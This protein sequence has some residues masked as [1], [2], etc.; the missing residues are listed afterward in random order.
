MDILA[1]QTCEGQYSWAEMQA[2]CYVTQ[3]VCESGVSQHHKRVKLNN[4]FGL[5]WT[6]YNPTDSQVKAAVVVSMEAYLP[7]G[8]A[9]ERV[10]YVSSLRKK[11]PGPVWLCTAALN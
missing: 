3:P 8:F 5:S 9:E 2:Q 10:A 11:T 1:P 6:F 7:Y 4:F